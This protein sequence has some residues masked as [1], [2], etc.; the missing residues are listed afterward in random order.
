MSIT[1][2]LIQVF[3][4]SCFC[5]N[6]AWFI[7]GRTREGVCRRLQS[8]EQASEGM[9]GNS[10]SSSAENKSIMM[11]TRLQVSETSQHRLPEKRWNTELNPPAVWS[12]IAFLRF[13]LELPFLVLIGLSLTAHY[14]YRLESCTCSNMWKVQMTPAVSFS[15][16]I[17]LCIIVWRICQYVSHIAEIE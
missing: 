1:E 16:E 17:E 9:H 5:S 15:D 2:K 8:H 13:H 3:G 4:F 7:H 12:V 11:L 14:N 10:P 6:H